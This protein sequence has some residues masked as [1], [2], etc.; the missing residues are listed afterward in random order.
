[1]SY[2]IKVA[3]T[4]VEIVHTG[5]IGIDEANQ[6]RN[7]AARLMFDKKLSRILADISGAIITA[8]TMGLFEFNASHYD[9]LP[10]G[11]MIATVLSAES[12]DTRLADFSETVAINR[13]IQLKLFTDR[14]AAR[15]WIYG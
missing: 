8:K 5:E 1:M 7:E 2:T 12:I 13:G 3:E 6:A 9:V 4:V 15:E 14:T 11:T 10:R